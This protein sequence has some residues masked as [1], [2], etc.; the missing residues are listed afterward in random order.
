MREQNRSTGMSRVVFLNIDRI[1]YD[2]KLDLSKLPE[3][4]VFYHEQE[5]SSLVERAQG[6]TVVVSKELTLSKETIEQFPDCVKMICEAG[7]GYNN[8]DIDA[9]KRKGILVCNTPAYSTQRVAH[10]VMLLLLMLASSMNKQQKM[11]MRQ[12][13]RNFSDHMM[14]DHVEV[15]QKVLGIIGEGAIGKAVK[16]LAL[17]F[18]MEVLIYTRTPKQDQEHVHYVSLK[19]VLQKSDFLSLHCPL[20]PSTKHL[21]DEQALALMKPTAFIIN[22]AR[23][24]LI[25]EQALIQALKKQKLA[26]AGLDVQEVEPLPQDSPLYKMDQVVLTPHMGWRGLETR[27]RLIDLVAETLHA[28]LQ[29]KPIRIV[30]Q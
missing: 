6:A 24:A 4:V 10:T 2:R 18:D 7:T 16:N 17:A 20:T 28:Y 15:N 25:D 3:D 11:L 8:I 22:T 12:D 26:G 30:S 9:C 1:D 27:Q 19:E 29:G 13:Y 23:G 14:V 21:I 5:A